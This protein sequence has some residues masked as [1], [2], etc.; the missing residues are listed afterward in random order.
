MENT[1][2][3]RVHPFAITH[4]DLRSEADALAAEQ[5]PRRFAILALDHDEQDG[6]IL[7]WGPRFGDGRVVL[8]GETAPI[9]GTFGSL[10]SA[11]RL[12]RYGGDTTYV[13]WIDP[14]PEPIPED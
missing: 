3:Q 14:A 5:A 2:A 9:R 6:V 4:D 11:L 8:T 12:F 13:T 7:A 1:T 10:D